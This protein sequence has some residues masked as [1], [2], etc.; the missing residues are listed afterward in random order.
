VQPFLRLESVSK[1]YRGGGVFDKG[2]EFQALTSVSFSIDEGKTLALVGPSGSGKSTLA[3]CLACLEPITSGS[4]WFGDSDI[5]AMAEKQQRR[6]RPEIQ[7]V[8]QDP[9]SSLNSRF[10]AEE[11]VVEPLSIQGKFSRSEQTARAHELLRKVGIPPEKAKNKANE[12]SGGQRQRIAIARSLALRPRVLILD[13]AVSALDCSVQAQ[14]VNLLLEL[15][16]QF[17]LTYVFITHDLAMAA[18]IAD[19]IAVMERGRIVEKGMPA[20]ILGSPQQEIT[21]RLIAASHLRSGA[22]VLQA[23]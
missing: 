10:T 5:A 7:L 1:E 16:S 13:E 12:F 3:L 22:E 23:I 19:E 4:I 6:I 15:Q 17:G 2:K 14:M 21:R 18:H 11:L 20:N 8:F 9:A